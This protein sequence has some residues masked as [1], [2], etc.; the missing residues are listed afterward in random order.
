MCEQTAIDSKIVA[1]RGVGVPRFLAEIWT[2]SALVC[3]A[4]KGTVAC[5]VAVD[6][7]VPLV[8]TLSL[9]T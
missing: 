2:F 4:S 8:V 9:A 1:N 6:L 3:A 5:C 7:L